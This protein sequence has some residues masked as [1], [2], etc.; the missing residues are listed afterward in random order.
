MAESAVRQLDRPPP[1]RTP[2]G[3]EI[4]VAPAMVSV[5]GANSE[6]DLKAVATWPEKFQLQGRSR[7]EIGL[8]AWVPIG[9]GGVPEAVGISMIL[10]GHDGLGAAEIS[11]CRIN[12]VGLTGLKQQDS[13][14]K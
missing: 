11:T 9:L 14:A 1:T 8:V 7:R 13:I 12:R 2:A 5:F 6:L 10:L 4:D 3:V